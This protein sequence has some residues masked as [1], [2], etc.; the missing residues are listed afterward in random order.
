MKQYN[1]YYQQFKGELFNGLKKREK[2]NGKKWWDSNSIN[3]EVNDVPLIENKTKV[4]SSEFDILHHQMVQLLIDY[5]NEHP[6]DNEVYSFSMDV[7][8]MK[9]TWLTYLNDNEKINIDIPDSDID[10]DFRSYT[11]IEDEEIIESYDDLSEHM[12][13][14]ISEFI[15]RHRDQLEEKLTKV[16]FTVL[17][18]KKS[19]EEKKWTPTT[20]SSLLF[21]INDELVVCSM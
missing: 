19:L 7:D 13:Y 20:E 16:Y 15:R 2:N 10:Y 14:F 18:L 6:L 4:L 9:G 11:A 3:D 17:D 12:Y 1:G 21:Y 5:I 8:L